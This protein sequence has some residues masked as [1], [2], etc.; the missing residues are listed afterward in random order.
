[1]RYVTVRAEELT[2]DGDTA[3]GRLE[4]VLDDL[5]GEG[6]AAGKAMGMVDTELVGALGAVYAAVSLAV[7][8]YGECVQSGTW[9]DTSTKGSMGALST[10]SRPEASFRRGSCC[11]EMI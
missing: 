8:R 11:A 4:L 6:V 3:V 1:M 9:I 10:I 7:G 2:F 5:L